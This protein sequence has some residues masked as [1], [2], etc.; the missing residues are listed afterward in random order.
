MNEDIQQILEQLTLEEKAKLCTGRDFWHLHGIERLDL[1]A[2]MLTDGPHG[3]RKQA[4]AGD[5]AGLNESVKAT[6]F[7]TAS[8]LAAS[9]NLDL[10]H[11]MGVA[12][13]IECRAEDVSVLLGPGTNMK[14]HPLGGRNFEYFSED[15]L[16]SGQL[17][18]AW[19]NGVQSQKV[20]TS[21]KHFA[22]N[23]HESSRMTVD[24]IVDER[25]LREIYLPAFEIAVKQSQPW[26]IM[27]SYNKI[28]GIYASEHPVL[29]D[30]ILFKQWNFQGI[31]VTDWGANNDRIAGIKAGQTLEMPSSG[32]INTRKIIQAINDGDL[33]IKQLDKSVARLLTLI[34]KSKATL[35]LEKINA[36]LEKHHQ[37]ARKIAQ[38]CCVLLKNED[39][40]LPLIPEKNKKIAVIGQ[41]ARESRYQGSGSSKIN[42]YKL[43]QPL[44][45]L[46]K[47]YGKNNITFEQGYHL[48]DSHDQDMIN[49][50][51]TLT[52]ESDIVI[53]V[54]GLTP[55]YESEGFD[56]THLDLPPTQLKLIDA[57]EK[58]LH[59][60]VM[61]LQN[62]APV[63]MPFINKVPA[64]L[65]AYLGGQAGGSAIAKI[66]SGEVNPSGKLA[67]TFPLDVESIASNTNFPGS[68][69]QV[70]Y[71]EGIWV[72]YR[73]FDT[74]AKKV[75]FPFGHGLSYTK[76]DYSGFKVSSA[77]KKQTQNTFELKAEDNIK[78]NIT[79]TNIGD[80]SG[81][82]TAQ[83][84]IGQCAPS[85]PRPLKEL[86]G[87]KKL[88]L[89]SGEPKEIEIELNKRDFSYWSTAQNKWVAPSGNYK[90]YVGA[91]I[92]DIRATQLI[93]INADLE[94]THRDENLS[95]YFTPQDNVFSE[96]DF[97][98]LLGKDIPRPIDV[99]PFTH[100]STLGEITVTATGKKVFDEY[101]EV[102]TKMVGGD[103]NS[104]GAE[105]ELIMATAMVSDMPLRNIPVFNEDV[106]NEQQLEELLIRVN[107]E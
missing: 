71:R 16:L 13:G 61:V 4:G 20:G 100:N 66:L 65:E 32:E 23:N 15:P 54:V 11:Q 68:S 89:E 19:I 47:I 51:V 103:Q 62:G 36:N 97:T 57:L 85:V 107:E 102:F 28:N 29:L 95:A 56:R 69:K 106:M 96:K 88:W 50:A 21:L 39:Q 80:V 94:N 70:Q 49:K 1:P 73:Y 34:L 33:S 14:R 75:L 22:V 74:A 27:S 37:L 25:T 41:L 99:R 8:G 44:D 40:F 26:T 52:N 45:E 2:I 63:A 58:S 3:L 82:E 43:E 60:T 86:K 79:I 78:V 53:L 48:D 105:A 90:I 18:A 12:L 59:K 5:L 42:P 46:V 76:F 31:I 83:L 93:T 9:W 24:V 55:K 91:S 87:Y 17:S 98:A 64:I 35:Q 101:L 38:Q 67:E 30:E 10:A 84:Y 81:F 6:C 72:G 7:P 104:A 77:N 92:E